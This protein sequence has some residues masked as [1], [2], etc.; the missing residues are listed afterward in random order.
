MRTSGLKTRNGVG[1]IAASVE[2]KLVEATGT[3]GAH[4]TREISV[5]LRLELR[6][7]YLAAG[8]IELD[9]RDRGPLRCPHSRVSYLVRADF[10]AYRI[11]SP[12]W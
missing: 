10:N 1:E 6:E 3:L 4:G 5:S 7:P 11:V 9:E 2:P 8:L 12:R